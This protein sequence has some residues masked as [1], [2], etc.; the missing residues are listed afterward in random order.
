MRSVILR[1][2]FAPRRL[3]RRDNSGVVALESLPSAERLRGEGRFLL[4][5]FIVMAGLV[6]AI[7]VFSP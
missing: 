5:R 6:P 4:R 2:P 1:C 7:H 3:N